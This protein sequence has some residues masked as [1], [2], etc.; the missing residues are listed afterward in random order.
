MSW[1]EL[2]V[3]YLVIGGFVIALP[4]IFFLITFMPG[5]MRTSG[6]VI[7]AKQELPEWKHRATKAAAT[8]SRDAVRHGEQPPRK[9]CSQFREHSLSAS[10]HRSSRQCPNPPL[11]QR[12]GALHHGFEG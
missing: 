8:R 12:L 9:A 7:G 3:G 4:V 11:I 5:L 2:A 10:P 6:E 1:S